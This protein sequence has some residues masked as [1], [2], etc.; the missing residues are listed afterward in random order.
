VAELY[1]PVP[2]V[3]DNLFVPIATA[4]AITYFIAQ[5]VGHGRRRD[6]RMSPSLALP[7]WMFFFC[8]RDQARCSKNS[9][10]YHFIF[11]VETSGGK[12]MPPNLSLS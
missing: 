1:C 10:T 5:Q 6:P 8:P 4:A 12:V 9:P 7:G 11:P 2:T 3:D